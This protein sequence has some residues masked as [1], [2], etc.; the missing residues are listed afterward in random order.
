[1]NSW[2]NI[3]S[4]FTGKNKKTVKP[5]VVAR[6][7]RSNAKLTKSQVSI[8]RKL[9]KRRKECGINNYADFTIFCNKELNI[10]KSRSVYNRIVRQQG[11][12]APVTKD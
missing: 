10:N 1:M 11:A 5:K 4:W 2:Y 9:H 8:I 7:K 6:K 12:Y 3:K